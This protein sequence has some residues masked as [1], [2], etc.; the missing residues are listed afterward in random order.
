MGACR[1]GYYFVQGYG[2]GLG[3]ALA[4]ATIAAIVGVVLFVAGLLVYHR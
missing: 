4:S 1:P 3:F 2:W